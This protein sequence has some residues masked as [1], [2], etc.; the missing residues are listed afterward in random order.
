MVPFRNFPGRYATTLIDVSAIFRDAAS[1]LRIRLSLN[2]R[3]DFLRSQNRIVQFVHIL[4][5][6]AR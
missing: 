5:N 3:Y 4:A 2:I 1:P 6:S